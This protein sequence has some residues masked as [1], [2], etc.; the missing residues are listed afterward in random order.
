MERHGFQTRGLRN[1]HAN[2]HVVSHTI[3]GWIFFMVMAGSDHGPGKECREGG[4]PSQTLWARVD[5]PPRERKASNRRAKTIFFAATPTT[6]LWLA[7]AWNAMFFTVYTG[8][9]CNCTTKFGDVSLVMS[10]RE[11]L[12]S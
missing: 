4:M 7:R 2:M 9:V 1:V 5:S 3:G 6:V 10:S 12:E 8:G 11:Q